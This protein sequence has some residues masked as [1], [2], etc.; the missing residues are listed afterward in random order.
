[1]TVPLADRL[2]LQAG[3]CGLLGSVLTSRLLLAA[4][5]DLE[6]GGPTR[7]VLGPLEDDPAG[8]V[9]ALRL[10]GALHRLVLER[11]APAL[12]LHYPSV[13]GT[14]GDLWPAAREVLEQQGEELAAL[15]ARPVQTNEVGRSSVL[16]GGLLHTRQACGAHRPGLP[17]RLLEVGASGG[18]NLLV[19]RYAYRVADGVVLGDPAS[20]M[21]LDLPWQGRHPAYDVVEVVQ[22]R[23]CDPAPLD[24]ASTQ[25]RLTLTS[26]VWADQVER[27][28]RLR[29]AFAVAGRHR[30]T[31][32]QLPASEFLRRELATPAPG[33]MTV[34]WQSVV[35]QYL[36]PQ[37]RRSVEALLVEAGERASPD[38]PLV[39]L[40][41]EPARTPDEGLA[42]LLT[43]RIW[44]GGR[45]RVLADCA[46]HG[47][48]VLW[49]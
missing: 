12:A 45:P 5:A 18:L 2:R 26:Y 24:P 48:P 33:V 36:A 23:G 47:P 21:R 41:M 28:E 25:D 17:V 20:P 15:V 38:A 46:G 42:F 1:M 35:Q 10:A 14:V 9:P 13:G 6:A 34:V 37:E 40:A 29:G 16:L 11:R 4:A 19:D 27:L 3:Q 39:H 32:E 22:R 8:S 49:R 31:V 7:E 30:I 43:M 44:P